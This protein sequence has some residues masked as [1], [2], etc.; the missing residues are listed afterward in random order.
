MSRLKKLIKEA[1]TTKLD[2]EAGEAENNT[3]NPKFIL[4]EG[5]WR[6]LKEQDKAVGAADASKE[7]GGEG[8]A[9]AQPAQLSRQDKVKLWQIMVQKAKKQGKKWSQLPVSDPTRANV[10]AAKANKPLPFPDAA[11]GVGGEAKPE[12]PLAAK[13]AAVAKKKEKVAALKKQKADEHRKSGNI[14]HQA[15]AIYKALKGGGTDKPALMRALVPNLKLGTLNDLYKAFD[16]V[17]Q[18]RKDTNAGDLIDWLR[19]DGLDGI[20]KVVKR[21]MIQQQQQQQ[22]QKKQTAVKESRIRVK[23]KS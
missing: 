15:H 14:I 9:A 19:D 17:L 21:K 6:L 11:A 18:N 20:A 12:D 13:K 10:R 5:N 8:D 16:K 23:K 7:G 3:S 1:I 22:Q 2:K 4:K